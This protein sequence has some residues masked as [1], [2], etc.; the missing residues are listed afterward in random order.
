MVVEYR[1]FR[2][3]EEVP[4]SMK[5]ALNIAQKEATMSAEALRKDLEYLV[6]RLQDLLG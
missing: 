2:S 4:E 5:M 1:L 6:S 3:N